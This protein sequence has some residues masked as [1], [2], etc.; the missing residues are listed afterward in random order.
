MSK[1][2]LPTRTTGAPPVRRMRFRFGEPEP[3]NRHFADGDIVLSHLTALL[4]AAF[5]PGEDSFV[6]SVRRVSGRIDDPALKKRAAGFIGQEAMHGQ[7]HRLLN[8]QLVRMGYVLV[9]V[10]NFAPGSRR[11]RAL[12][13]AE[14]L[15]PAHVHLAATAAAEHFT[16]MLARRVLTSPELQEI[17]TASPE[18]R[19]LL[20]WH[21]LEELEHKSVA[22]DVYRATGGGEA[23]RIGVMTIPYVGIIPFMALAVGLSILT[24]PQGWRPVTVT[25]QAVGVLRGPLVKGLLAEI[26]EYL[27]P[28]FHPD[29]LDT[30]SLVQQW[31]RELF[32]DHGL[33]LDRV[34]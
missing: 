27:K 30:E 34:R 21:A 17:A 10:P 20:N 19:N 7:Q 9:R 26:R 15:L 33:L 28:G 29:D 4:S 32:G 13:R 22:F 5:P 2:T 14:R 24:D 31:Q 25:R 16:S 6:R 11:E 18:V 12:I 1:S 23:V 8:D 3:M